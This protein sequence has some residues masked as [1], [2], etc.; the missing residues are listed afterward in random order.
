MARKKRQGKGKALSVS[1]NKA[2]LEKLDRV[3]KIMNLVTNVSV[4]LMSTMMGAF[5]QIMVETTG[6]IASGMTS[7]MAG[8]EAGEK[9]KKEFK[10]KMPEADAKMKAMISDIRK[11]MYAQFEKS[12][13]DIEPYL[14]D[15]AFDVGPKT[16]DKYDFVLPKLTEELE[17]GVLAQ[18]SLLITKEDVKFGEMFGELSKWLNS[19]PKPPEK[20]GKE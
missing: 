8:E 9:V 19:L 4:L 2:S 11:D 12:R 1:E 20:K 3:Q 14:Y 5:S 10:E 6:A 18:Y 13:K 17:D 16:V 7:A 15:P